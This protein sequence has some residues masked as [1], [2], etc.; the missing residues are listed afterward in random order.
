MN[1]PKTIRNGPCGGVR[2]DGTCEVKPGMKCVWVQA[3][4]GA[5]RMKGGE[6]IKDIEFAVDHRDKGKST[7]LRIARGEIAEKVIDRR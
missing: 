5:T 7:W 4:D 1:C 6:A 3:W 2:A